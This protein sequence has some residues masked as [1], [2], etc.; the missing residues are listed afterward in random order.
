MRNWNLKVHIDRIHKGEF[1]PLR[2]PKNASLLHTQIISGPPKSI[3]PDFETHDPLEWS[4]EFKC[5]LQQI[6]GLSYFELM[7]LLK[8]INDKLSR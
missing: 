3:I 5:I 6:D 7:T 8:A 1:N 2:K 4:I